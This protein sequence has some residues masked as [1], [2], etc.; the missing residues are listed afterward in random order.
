MHIDQSWYQRP[1]GVPDS[2]TAGGVVAR[3]VGDQILLALAQEQI[4]DDYVLPKG[5]VEP[6]E[7]IEEAA[8]REIE[9][10]VGISDLTLIELLGVKERLDFNKTEWKKTHY[11]LFTT[12]QA[13]AK[14]THTE[15]HEKMHWVPLDPVPKFFWPEQQALVEENRERILNVLNGS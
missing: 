10:E 14:P 6:G 2:E 7:S 9:E 12:E 15:Q 1:Q 8:R 11:F 13:N 5:H 4:Y 3:K